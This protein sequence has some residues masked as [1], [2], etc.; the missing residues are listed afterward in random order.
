MSADFDR[1]QRAVV[2]ACE[3]VFAG[4]NIAVN[5][6]ILGHSDTLLK[7]DFSKCGITFPHVA[8]LIILAFYF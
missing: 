4:R 3:I 8:A 1:L 6:G 7:Y 5:A 2:L